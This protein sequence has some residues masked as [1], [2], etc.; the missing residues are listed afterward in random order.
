MHLTALYEKI[1]GQMNDRELMDRGPCRPAADRRLGGSRAYDYSAGQFYALH[2]HRAL[3]HDVI[4]SAETVTEY[5]FCLLMGLT[6]LV[7]TA[8]A[9]NTLLWAIWGT[10]QPGLISLSGLC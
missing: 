9:A 5:Q 4:F 1:Q 7:P 3:T 10:I 8:E 2:G 6:R